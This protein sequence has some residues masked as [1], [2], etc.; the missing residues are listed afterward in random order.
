MQRD[1]E[2]WTCRNRH[3]VSIEYSECDQCGTHFVEEKGFGTY[4]CANCFHLKKNKYKA[5]CSRTCGYFLRKK[6]FVKKIQNG[7]TIMG[8]TRWFPPSFFL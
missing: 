2:H 8:I 7:I 5:T 4:F 6:K 1:Y 3:I